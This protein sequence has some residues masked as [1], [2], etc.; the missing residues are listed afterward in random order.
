MFSY[1]AVL[2]L[3]DRIYAAAQAPAAWPAALEALGSA[4]GS[5][6][7]SLLYHNLQSHEGG[8]DV[9]V[10]VDPEARVEYEAHY[11]RLDP[12]GNS[13][14]A[15]MMVAPGAIFDGDQLVPR[16]ELQRTEYYNDFARRHDLTRILVGT[17]LIDGPVVSVISLIRRE[18]D[19]P[20]GREERRTLEAVM[21]HL[22]RAMQMHGLLLP[23]GGG[24]LY[25]AVMETL[26][27]LGTGVALLSAGGRAL[28][29][30][31][32]AEQMLRRR[33][34]L[35]VDRGSVAAMVPQE[36]EA[37][38]FLVR[39]AARQDPNDAFHA[40]GALA[41]SRPSGRRA[42]SLLVSPL[43]RGGGARGAQQPAVVLFI[44]DPEMHSGS[45]TELLMRLFQLT[46]S[47]ARLAAIV[48]T[49]TVLGEAAEALGICRDTARAQLK[50]VFAKTGTRRQ[51]ELVRLIAR[52]CPLLPE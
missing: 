33:D 24:D 5:E 11:H 36:R 30:N 28:F 23:A 18:R 20:H 1:E 7:A 45:N 37:L 25:G 39:R 50:S 10:R 8:V 12:W 35:L 4:T 16:P 48:G 44:T 47:E 19:E 42:Y 26:D 46:D 32:A 41:V 34:G 27:C 13:P 38:R 9:A 22:I 49:G 17:I 29:L 15:P 2:D 51:A 6:A 14:K 40:G 52:A 43:N 21:P 31:R 3:V